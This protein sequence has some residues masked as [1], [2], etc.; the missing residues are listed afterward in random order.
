VNGAHGITI[1]ERNSDGRFVRVQR[2]Y[3]HKHTVSALKY[4][5]TKKILVSCGT[6]GVF[7][8]DMEKYA[9]KKVIK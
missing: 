8:W 9:C 4:H 3:G 7:I 1:C 6:D 2:L 5:P